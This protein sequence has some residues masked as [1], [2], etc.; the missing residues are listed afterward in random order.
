LEYG[1]RL[2]ARARG[3]L[4]SGAELFKGAQLGGARALGIS[5]A[6][7]EV[8]ASADI[9]SLDTGH[10]ALCGKRG[11]TRLDS[12]IFAARGGAVDAVWRRGA[13]VVERGRHVNAESIGERYRRTMARVL[14]V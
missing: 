7:L 2:T 14:A 4:G 1:Q 6:G 5:R 9:V 3:R 13:R 8:G 10:P 11:D 12:W